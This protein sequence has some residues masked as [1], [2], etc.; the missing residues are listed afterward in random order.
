MELCKGYESVR[1]EG[2]GYVRSIRVRE[3][4]VGVM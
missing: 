1:G 2:W 4:K 3:E